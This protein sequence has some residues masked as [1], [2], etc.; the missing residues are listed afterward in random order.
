MPH[1]V[2]IDKY[3]IRKSGGRG[4]CLT[5]PKSYMEDL[6]LKIGQ[7]CVFYR[8]GKLLIIAPEGV[9]AKAEIL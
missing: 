7:S 9:D 5:V 4:E 8:Q 3:K 2:R 6:E 1:L